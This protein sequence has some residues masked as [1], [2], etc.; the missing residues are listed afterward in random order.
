MARSRGS[1]Q[2]ADAKLGDFFL[3]GVD[4][5]LKGLTMFVLGLKGVVG[6][7]FVNDGLDAV[8]V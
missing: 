6:D 3:Q 2:A 7:G 4:A 8:R 1:G 5:F